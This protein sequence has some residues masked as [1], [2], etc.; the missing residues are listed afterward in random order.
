MAH[1]MMTPEMEF[2][3]LGLRQFGITRAAAT[4][5][6]STAPTQQRQRAPPT[7]IDKKP[8]ARLP[9]YTG[10][11]PGVVADS[12]LG[13]SYSFITGHRGALLHKDDT[14]WQT[15]YKQGHGNAMF[16]QEPE[17]GRVFQAS[18][19][20]RPV[21][22]TDRPVWE[23][24]K[25]FNSV[26][27]LN[28]TG[29]TPGYTGHVPHYKFEG[30]LGLS[31]AKACNKGS[32]NGPPDGSQNPYRHEAPPYVGGGRNT[33]DPAEG[34]SGFVP[35]L[36]T[37]GIGQR[38]KVALSRSQKAA[39]GDVRALRAEHEKVHAGYT[40]SMRLALD[41]ASPHA[42]GAP[43]GDSR[44]L[45]ASRARVANA[46]ANPPPAHISGYTGFR[47]GGHGGSAFSPERYAPPPK[48]K[49]N[50]EVVE[51]GSIYLGD[52]SQEW[53][54]GDPYRSMSQQIGAHFAGASRGTLWARRR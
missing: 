16:E 9:G 48:V 32:Q 1:K 3:E 49:A 51:A 8:T 34:Y 26:L 2:R 14:N 31:F 12:L 15:D 39:A 10:H 23:S 37:V 50:G 29:H 45:A 13:R 27:G 33:Q 5:R 47:P 18:K 53:N 30:S 38:Y 25:V 36:Q 28:E 17:Y 43:M 6:P 19:A 11:Q 35:H 21:H 54:C 41:G 7:M 46:E 20:S 40:P 24:K 52:L 42:G 22:G 44:A 4:V